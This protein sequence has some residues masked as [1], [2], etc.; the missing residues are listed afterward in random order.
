[1][2][3]LKNA[4]NDYNEKVKFINDNYEVL[5][6]AKKYGMMSDPYE[7]FNKEDFISDYLLDND[8]SLT[9]IELEDL[10]VEFGDYTL[11]IKG[12]DY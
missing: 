7:Y 10:I 11:G 6:T 1:M 8:S 3:N 9:E 2:K 5:F 4:I 12:E